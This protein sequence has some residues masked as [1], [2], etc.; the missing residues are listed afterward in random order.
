M[1]FVDKYFSLSLPFPMFLFLSVVFELNGY[2][3]GIMSSIWGSRN[4]VYDYSKSV[5]ALGGMSSLENTTMTFHAITHRYNDIQIVVI[6]LIV[7][8]VRCSIGK[9]CPN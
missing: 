4:I 3:V 6:H 9:F 8:S 1:R 5:M 7:F 2:E